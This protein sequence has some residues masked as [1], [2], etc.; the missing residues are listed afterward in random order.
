MSRILH[1]ILP[2]RGQK[3]SQVKIAAFTAA[4]AANVVTLTATTLTTLTATVGAG[5]GW[6]VTVGGPAG[7]SATLTIAG[8]PK[9][10]DV[11][12]LVVQGQTV[13]LG[14]DSPTLSTTAL[15]NNMA[16]QLLG[17]FQTNDFLSKIE[18]SKGVAS[19]TTAAQCVVVGLADNSLVDGRVTTS[20]NLGGAF[21]TG[22]TWVAM[23]D[24]ETTL[25]P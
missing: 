22:G 6:T 3:D 23:N 2:C 12:T 20:T 24:S 21:P 18:C 8:S 14:C 5:N 11:V 1:Q 15:A 9:F 13:L 10:G 4:A 16:A 7:N 19:T 17:I 25:N